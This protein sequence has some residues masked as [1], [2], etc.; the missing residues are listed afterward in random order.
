[1]VRILSHI[2]STGYANQLIGY[3]VGRIRLIFSLP[4]R[5]FHTLFPHI[6]PPGHLAYVEWFTA[7]TAR[8]PEHGMYTIKKCRDADGAWLAS[9]IEVRQIRR[10]CHLFPVFGHIA[11]CEWSSST[12][13]DE[14]K[15]FLVNPFSDQHMYM[16][17]V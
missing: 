5:S 4:K 16:T 1:M 10:S 2:T 9:V 11:P 17:L 15:S 6:M 13:L 3:R 14:C 7:F 8:D 12:V